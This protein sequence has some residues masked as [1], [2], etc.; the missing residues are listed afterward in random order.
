MHLIFRSSL[1]DPQ[2]PNH[3]NSAAIPVVLLNQIRQIQPKYERLNATVIPL[4]TLN[5]ACGVQSEKKLGSLSR[6]GFNTDQA[7]MFFDYFP[8]DC[9]AEAGASFL[10]CIKRFENIFQR[11]FSD[12]AAGV[13]DSQPDGAARAGFNFKGA[14]GQG[15]SFGH[16]FDGVEGNV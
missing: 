4:Q 11:F 2:S 6:Y 15:A 7:P 8:A 13:V 5:S 3:R 16:R 10:G 9:Q 12:A 1:P 14:K